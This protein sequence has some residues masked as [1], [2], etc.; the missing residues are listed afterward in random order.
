MGRRLSLQSISRQLIY[1]TIALH[2]APAGEGHD[3]I[4]AGD[5]GA[6]QEPAMSARI[7]GGNRRGSAVVLRRVVIDRC[8]RP[9]RE[10]AAAGRAELAVSVVFGGASGAG[11]HG[12]FGPL[13]GAESP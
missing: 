5:F 7:R 4:A 3:A 11:F 8:L 12:S 6:R 9:R 1:S 10:H 13:R 2:A